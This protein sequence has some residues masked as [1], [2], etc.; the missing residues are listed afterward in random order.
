MAYTAIDNPEL[1]FQAKIYT[2]NGSTQSITLDGDTDMSPNLVWF[3]G[4]SNADDKPFFDTVRGTGEAIYSDLTNAEVSSATTLTA[5]DS[6]GFSIGNNGVVNTDTYTYVAWCWKAN[7]SGS[8]NTDG[9]VTTTVSANTDAGFSIVT[10]T[11]TGASA[12][13]GHG[14]SKAPEISFYKIRS[15]AYQW[16]VYIGNTLSSTGLV[17]NDDSAVSSPGGTYGTHDADTF[18]LI[19]NADVNGSSKTY[20]SYHFHSV[21]GYSK[22]G[23]YTGNGDDDGAFIY[24][25]FRP[26]W[27]MIKKS[28]GV[29]EWAIWDNKRPTFNVTD[30]IIYPN[31]SNAE[32]SDN[33]NGLDFCANG[34][35]LRNA[36][37]DLFNASGGTY[38]YMAFAEAPFVNSNGVPCNAR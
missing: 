6:D 3:S 4:R 9:S 11:G 36:A 34:V 29:N 25:G 21:D 8:S 14:L 23:S 18:N 5:F 37:G 19:T 28:S 26:A 35:K 32:A 27:V 7:G 20:V 16:M 17:L 12:T 31:L 13:F 1:Y 2:G 22:V 33:A 38:I 10:Y 15:E 30:D 24:T